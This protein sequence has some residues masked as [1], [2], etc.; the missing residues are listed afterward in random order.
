MV[1]DFDSR[2]IPPE[3][4][5]KILNHAL[6]GPS[7]GFTQGFEF[8]VFEGAEQTKRFWAATPWWNEPSWDG[9]RNSPFIIVPMGHEAAYV[10]RYSGPENGT[11]QRQTGAEFPAPYWFTDAGFAAMLILLSAVDAGL[12]AFY[13]SVGPT[14]REIPQ[15]RQN[16]GIPDD[17]TPIGAI[18]IGYPGKNDQP[19]VP[20][21]IRQRRR[22]P[23]TVFHRGK[24]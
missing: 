17:Y 3:T 7:S 6:R 23:E 10:A 1:R 16:L 13:F 20:D 2:P 18:A 19:G 9:T 22:S 15:F 4:T 24:W 12:G 5:Q 14:S 8:L 11:R 21:T